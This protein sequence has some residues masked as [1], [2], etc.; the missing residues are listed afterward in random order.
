M[1]RIIESY[2][3]LHAIVLINIMMIQEISYVRV[4]CI[5]VSPA[6]ALLHVQLVMQPRE[7]QLISQNVFA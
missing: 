1:L 5:S 6:R 7:V 4:A 2:P 3:G